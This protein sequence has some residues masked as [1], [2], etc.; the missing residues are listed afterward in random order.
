MQRLVDDPALAVRLGGR[1]YLLDAGGDVPDIGAHVYAVEAL[2]ERALRRRDSARISRD[3]GPWR[4]TFDTNPDT[5]NLH[6]VMCEEH[7]PHSPNQARRTAA[8][9]SR[10]TM[11]F[12]LIERVVAE[13]APH[14]LREIVPSTMG[15]PLLYERFEAILDLC[16]THGVKLNLTTNGSFPRLGAQAWAERIVP[17]TCDVKIS[18]NGATRET[19]ESIMLGSNWDRLLANVRT[20]VAI[21]DRHAANGGNRCRVT[22]QLTFLERNVEELADIVGLAIGLGVDRVKGHH[23]W[24]HFPEL[25][26]QSMR[27]SPESIRRWNAAVRAAQAAADERRLPNGH[28]ILLDN[29][30]VLADDA[31]EDLAP[32]GPCP[33]LGREVWVSAAGRFDPCC[34]PDAQRRGLGELGN[35]HERGLLE[36]W[37]GTDYRRLLATYRN[38]PLCRGCNMRRPAQG[39]R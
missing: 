12:E 11:P 5:C 21:R 4:V 37:D 17:V 39:T 14:G 23:V 2:Y 33:F 27:R 30:F 26:D 9:L 31:G 20:F 36:I 32:G 16:S 28:R 22:F 18:F 25:A 10:R 29:L 35:L 8:G 15:E 13:A 7:S 38:R 3:A 1:G 19:Q 34:A 24:A 6:C